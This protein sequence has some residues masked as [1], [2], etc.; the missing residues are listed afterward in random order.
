MNQLNIK[1]LCPKWVN[2]LMGSV[3]TI[4][5]I[6]MG[7]VVIDKYLLS[8]PTDYAFLLAISCFMGASGITERKLTRF[9]Q[10]LYVIGTI[11]FITYLV[12]IIYSITIKS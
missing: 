11:S 9:R 8:T 5:M 12:N 2:E 4:I 6:V 7:V 1:K 10:F 3:F